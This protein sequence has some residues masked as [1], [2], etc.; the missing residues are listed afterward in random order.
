MTDS[1]EISTKASIEADNFRE[2]LEA[3]K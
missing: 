2:M 3:A 1:I